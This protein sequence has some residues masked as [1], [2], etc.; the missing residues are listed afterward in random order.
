M[1]IH[2]NIPQNDCE[3]LKSNNSLS[4]DSKLNNIINK[5]I[6]NETTDVTWRVIILS[7]KALHRKDLIKEVIRYLFV[8]KN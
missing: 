2:L 5:W 8:N 1:G 6:H 4:D 7:L 3:T